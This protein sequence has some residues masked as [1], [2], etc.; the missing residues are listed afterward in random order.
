MRRASPRFP[1]GGR[2]LL[3]YTGYAFVQATR[4]RIV[5]A[6][7]SS[8]AHRGSRIGWPRR[9]NLGP[10]RQQTGVTVCAS[11]PVAAQTANRCPR[12]LRLPPRPAL[13]PSPKPPPPGF[14]PPTNSTPASPTP[15]RAYFAARIARRLPAGV[16]LAADLEP[17]M[18]R[19]L[20]ER[21]ARE[22]LSN[23]RPLLAKADEVP[24]AEP[25]DLV[26]V[27][28]TYHHLSERV[29]YFRRLAKQLRP[30]GRVAVIDFTKE[31]PEGPPE[32]RLTPVQVE[33]EMGEAGYS[34]EARHEVLPR[35]YFLVFRLG[36]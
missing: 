10:T 22:G 28:E 27:V 20:R 8:P 33:S 4:P 18:V 26:L 3:S 15:A 35:Q 30:G 32:H 36:S 5:R 19:Y 11:Y 31:S 25:V 34:L 17:D 9:E 13:G 6:R 7:P 16:V 29:A 2:G 12:P 23:L 24:L 14:A 1:H 21:A